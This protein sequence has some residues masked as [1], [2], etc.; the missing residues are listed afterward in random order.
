VKNIREAMGLTQK[1]L[2]SRVGSSQQS[3]ARLEKNEVSPTVETLQKTAN[4]LGCDLL[5][6][7]APKQEIEAVVTE[8]A[9]KKADEIISQSVANSAME[10]QKPSNRIVELSK[11]ALV[12]DLIDNKR[13]LLW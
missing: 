4:A 7:F 13:T 5:I 1:Q 3:I 6:T 9:R 11:E 8:K 2:A 10:L 12:D